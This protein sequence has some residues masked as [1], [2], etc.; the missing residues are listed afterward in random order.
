MSS[1][2]ALAATDSYC[3]EAL[4]LR[5]AADSHDLLVSSNFTGYIYLSHPLAAR[6]RGTSSHDFGLT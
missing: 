2:A 4:S 1:G 6:G 5:K 3:S